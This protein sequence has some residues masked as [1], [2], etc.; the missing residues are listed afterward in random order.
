MDTAILIPA[1][2]PDG[3][4]ID[5][6][7]RLAAELPGRRVVVVDDGSAPDGADICRQAARIDGVSL[8]RHPVNLGKG[9]ALKTGLLHI[10]NVMPQCA[11][12]I[13]ADADGQ[14]TPEDIGR[15]AAEAEKQPGVLLLGARRFDGTVP[16][17]SLAGNRIT[18]FLVRLLLGM[19]LSDT[20]TGLRAI[21]RDFIPDLLPIPYNRYE[22]ELEM[23][24]TAKRTGR[25]A[26]EIGIAT[27]YL[28]GNAS[29]HFNPLLDSFKI[30]FVLFRYIIV[31]LI[32]ALA[33][34]LVYVPT[35]YCCAEF[36]PSA[37]STAIAVAAG[38]I[39]G[40]A[41]QYSLVRKV[42]FYSRSSMLVTLP[43][44]IFLVLCSGCASYL[45]LHSIESSAHWNF[46]IAKPAAELIVYLANFLIQRDLIFDNRRE[47]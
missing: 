3:R 20:Q 16:L 28:E 44:Y 36:Y 38:R 22:F 45:I 39:A 46:Y 7:R 10:V 30:Y 13:T 15:L 40:A 12:V 32:T 29:S 43:K 6:L 18:A 5:L 37:A 42:V 4:L 23:L 26:A 41:V 19:K 14:H 1:Y 21:P 27:V 47:H 8:L 33:D 2:N 34:Y 11:C 9:A 17:R 24:L 25:P 31:S 35:L